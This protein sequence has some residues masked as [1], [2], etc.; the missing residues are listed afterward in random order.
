MVELPDGGE[1]WVHNLGPATDLWSGGEVMPGRLMILSSVDGA[2]VGE[3]RRADILD[4]GDGTWRE[5]GQGMRRIHAG[6]QWRWGFHRGAYWYVN[7]PLA[8]RFLTDTSGALVRW[9]P[10]TGELIHIVGGRR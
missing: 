6:F 5:V 1:R 2:E 4:L 9:D 10:E 3:G 8:N 7:R